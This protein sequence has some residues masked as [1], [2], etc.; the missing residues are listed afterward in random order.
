MS[1]ANQSPPPAAPGM[2]ASRPGRARRVVVGAVAL[3][4]VAAVVYGV[5]SPS[6]G[7]A[8]ACPC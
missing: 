7:G 2:P 5:L 1:D 4:G 3:L 6:K 8:A